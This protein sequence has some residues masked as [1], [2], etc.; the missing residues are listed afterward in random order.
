MARLSSSMTRM[1]EWL[2]R[3]PHYMST[4]RHEDQSSWTLKS[5]STLSTAY[6]HQDQLVAWG[7]ERD[8]VLLLL[9][10]WSVRDLSVLH[11][12]DK[13][14][15]FSSSSEL[16]ITTEIPREY[17]EETQRRHLNGYIGW[18]LMMVVV[19]SLSSSL[20]SKA[21]MGKLDYMA[22]EP[23]W[24][25]VLKKFSGEIMCQWLIRFGFFVAFTQ[26]SY[27][28]HDGLCLLK[29]GQEVSLLGCDNTLLQPD[30]G[31]L[32]HGHGSLADGDDEAG[33]AELCKI[34]YRLES[35]V[36]A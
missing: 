27:Q 2:T 21:V 1:R 7:V 30:E 12:V 5:S 28:H 13:A 18:T 14:L 26:A 6:L 17:L 22:W 8:D 29:R 36:F 9:E 33:R 10:G 19:V 11:E 15:H 32:H 35:I 34:T 25:I 23:P 20:T 31:P 16:S 3:K 4:S 24:I